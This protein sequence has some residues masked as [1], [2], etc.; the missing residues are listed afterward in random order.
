MLRIVLFCSIFLLISKSSYGQVKSL[1]LEIGE[2]Y[3]IPSPSNEKITLSQKD[4]IQLREAKN[5]LVIQAKQEGLA[6]LHQNQNMTLIKV[7]TDKSG[8][9]Q[10]TKII[11]QNPWLQWSLSKEHQGSLVITGSLYRF[12]TWKHLIRLSKKYHIPFLLYTDVS[13]SV[14]KS[15]HLFFQSMIKRESFQIQWSQPIT[16]WVS[17]NQNTHD[18]KHYGVRTTVSDHLFLPPLVKIHFV[19]AQISH[20]QSNHF[21]GGLF[22]DL[23]IEHLVET[24]FAYAK[25]KGKG[26]VMATSKLMAESKKP[27]TYF[28]GGETPIHT[29]HIENQTKNIQWKPYGISLKFTPTV[30]PHLHILMDISIDISE[31]D[32]TYSTE[33]SPATKN[34]R[35]SSTLTIPN[36]KTVRLS[37]LH[38]VEKGKSQTSPISFSHLISHFLP[39]LWMQKGDTQEKT[40]S[41]LFIQPTIIQR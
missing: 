2:S 4:I 13:V 37:E 18:F 17:K 41:W 28:I 16:F 26:Q 32:H 21:N 10:F 19:I 9:I 8:W 24:N 15:A 33:G 25:N 27:V 6:I 14:R 31:V 30:L 1:F 7:L 3:P 12:Q 29:F 22:S 23:S 20:H 35:W 5:H 38:R 34:H 40:Q 36:N 11:D 39:S